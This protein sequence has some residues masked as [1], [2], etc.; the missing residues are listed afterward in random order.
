MR[1]QDKF[2]FYYQWFS[3]C[4]FGADIRPHSQCEKGSFFPNFMGKIPNSVVIKLCL[5]IVNELKAFSNEIKSRTFLLLWSGYCLFWLCKRNITYKIPG[6][7]AVY[8]VA[9]FVESGVYWTVI[10]LQK[11]ESGN[12][13]I[14]NKFILKMFISINLI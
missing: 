12:C 2:F 6:T 1:V 9:W 5:K 4:V 7:S 10:K 3:D 13:S 8:W 14:W 11:N